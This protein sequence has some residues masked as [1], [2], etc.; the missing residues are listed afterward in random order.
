[1][2]SSQTELL[3]VR[4]DD[5][6]MDQALARAQEF[7]AEPKFHHIV[8]P[9]PEFLLEASEHERFR[10][11]LNRSDLSLPEGMGLKVGSML[12]GRPMKHRV[13]GADFVLGLMGLARQGGQRVFLFGSRPSVVEHTVRALLKQFPGLAIVGYESGYRG[14]WQRLHD[15]RVVEKIHRAKPDILLVALGAP[16]QELW[17]DQ[18]R[19][20]LHDVRIAIGVGRTFDYVAGTI[21]RAPK[22]VRRLGFEWLHTWL[23]ARSYHHPEF[24]RQRVRNATW[25]FLATIIRH[26]K[27]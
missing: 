14:P 17:I 9:G 12:I 6:S 2:I 16:K 1:M 4:I 8:T 24:R 23:F 26:G 10:T 11:I 25:H 19:Q 21:K 7:L 27:A 15:H 20:A 18:H 13:P 22:V 5:L 3:G